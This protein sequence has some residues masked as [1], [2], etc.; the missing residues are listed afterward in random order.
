MAENPYDIEVLLDLKGIF[1][2]LIYEKF[3]YFI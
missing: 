3:K 1:L 2:N